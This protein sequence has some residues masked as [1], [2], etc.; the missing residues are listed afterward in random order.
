MDFEDYNNTPSPTYSEENEEKA[1]QD[2]QN[3]VYAVWN[4]MAWVPITINHEANR[5]DSDR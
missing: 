4:G 2:I 5:E 1:Y 3:R